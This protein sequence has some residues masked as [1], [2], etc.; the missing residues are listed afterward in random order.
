MGLADRDY[1]RSDNRN[2]YR[3]PGTP[4]GFGRLTPRSALT[5]T[6]W[7]IIINV[8][9]FVLDL[10][11][12]GAVS[13][14]TQLADQLIKPTDGADTR[15]VEAAPRRVLNAYGGSISSKP[16][17]RMDTG[18]EVGRRLYTEMFPLESIGF[19]STVKIAHLEV[20]RFVTF[21]FVHGGF[22]HLA[23]NMI[24]LFFFGP[25]VE[26][27]LGSRRLF[28]AFYLMCGMCGAAL[29]LLLNLLGTLS[30]SLPLGLSNPPWVPLV[31][32]S[33]GVFGIIMACAFVAG[34]LRMYVFGVI[35]MKIRTGAYLF[36]AI[37]A[38]NLIIEGANAGGDAAHIGGAI[39]G[40]FFI[41]KPHL[42]LNFFD[43]FLRT[44]DRHPPL[45]RSGPSGASRRPSGGSGP[46]PFPDQSRVDA[47]LDKIRTRGEESLTD[48]ERQILQRASERRQG[49]S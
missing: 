41:R 7:L 35:P 6:T 40:F 49:R 30:P 10:V 18:E 28:L 21:Q 43:D 48:E 45:R 36:V 38:F 39:G 13:A 47:I 9:V 20:W 16:I 5:A 37:A 33:A 12:G 1:M 32:A 15:V 44:K 42:L 31:G 25:L 26:R 46:I 22:W 8:A 4:M 34:D 24:G 14:H 19:F 2:R 23:L 17:I 27:Y 29:Y 3:P 11:I